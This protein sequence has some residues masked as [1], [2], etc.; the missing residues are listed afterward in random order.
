MA[1]AIFHRVDI[2]ITITRGEDGGAL[3]R[4]ASPRATWETRMSPEM[5][6]GWL[7]LGP[8]APLAGLAESLSLTADSPT[9]QEWSNAEIPVYSQPVAIIAR[10]TIDVSDLDLAPLAWERS[11]FAHIPAPHHYSRIIRV[12]PVVP[13]VGAVPLTLPLRFLQVDPSPGRKP[14]QTTIREV[15]GSHPEAL[16]AQAVQIE[17]CSFSDL[18]AF[19]ARSAWPTADVLHFDNFPTLAEPEMLLSTADPEQP[20]TL[21]W[22]A[23]LADSWQTRLLVI[24]CDTAT[25]AAQARRLA[26]ALVNRGGPAVLV[27]HFPAGDPEY[28]YNRFYGS[29]IH[30]TP[31]DVVFTPSSGAGVF[32]GPSLFVGR[33][34][35]DALRVSAIGEGLIRLADELAN[36]T[37][38]ESLMVRREMYEM[39]ERLKPRRPSEL[40]DSGVVLD[41]LKDYLGGLSDNLGNLIFEFHEGEGLL[42]LTQALGKIRGM[43]GWQPPQPTPELLGQTDVISAPK[44]PRERF[45]NS[46]LSSWSDGAFSRLDQKEACLIIGGTYYLGVQIGRQDRLVRVYGATP[47]VEERF[48]WTPEMAGVWLEVGVTGLDFEVLGGPVQELW[49]PQER[50]SETI[51]FAV[52]PRTKHVA[53]LRFCVYYKSD[54]IQSFGLAALTQAPHAKASALK[55]GTKRLARALNLPVA[56]I[57]DVSYLAKLEYSVTARLDGVRNRPARAISIVANDHDGRSVITVKSANVFDIRTNDDLPQRV[58]RVR[59][60]LEA[61]ATPPIAGVD[62]K[63]WAYG[64]GTYDHP[65]AGDEARLKSALARLADLG[66]KLY[67]AI[68]PQECRTELAKT[69]ETEKQIIHVAHILLNK[70]LPWAVLYDCKYAPGRKL[71]DDQNPVAHDVCLAALPD[72]NGQFPVTACGEHANCLLHPQRVEER[73]AKGEPALLPDTV[74]CPLHFWGF[75]HIIEL[76]PQQA[77][78]PP[79]NGQPVTGP[80]AREQET[81]ILASQPVH[82]TAAIHALLPLAEAHQK[83][84]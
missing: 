26:T 70:V 37:R 56:A 35:S 57:G 50:D 24:H 28:F 30:D 6:R 71:D 82:M 3:A 36:P 40:R 53:R 19:R 11:L 34:R 66:W 16:I 9:W 68:V 44:T 77:S 79:T 12:S 51:Y 60:G 84:C 59:T 14:L 73:K 45:I 65:N 32:G 8:D 75:K 62:R 49:L 63:N 42:P 74:V 43:L 48:K 46:H 81:C 7:A 1:K 27:G 31:L 25:Q 41:Q 22:L 18:D 52:V 58:E 78:A 13:R 80:Q 10:L 64:F 4:V 20:G 72:E 76:P 33:G 47:I 29:I 21:G 61:I 55:A 39:L 54:V 23:R 83:E 38:P 2:A 15:F 17:S 69:L 67:D 5:V